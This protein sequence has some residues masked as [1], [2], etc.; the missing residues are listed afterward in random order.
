M[1]KKY[2]SQIISEFFLTNTGLRKEYV[3]Q[4]VHFHKGSIYR[5]VPNL[6]TPWCDLNYVL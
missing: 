5:E 4:L 6:V 2:R 3:S 1:C